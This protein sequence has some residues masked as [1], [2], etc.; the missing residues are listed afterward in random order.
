VTF[1]AL[2]FSYLPSYIHSPNPTYSGIPAA[3]YALAE[4][5]ASLVTATTPLLKPLMLQFK[6]V[7]QKPTVIIT[8]KRYSSRTY[9][10]NVETDVTYKSKFDDGQLNR[11]LHSD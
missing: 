10:E 9:A 7:G 2:R 3:I 11:A 4:V 8:A 5:H 1:A 6:V